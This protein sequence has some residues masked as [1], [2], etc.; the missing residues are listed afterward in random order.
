MTGF[1]RGAA[2]ALGCALWLTAPAAPLRADGPIFIRDAEIEATLRRVADPILRAA[3]VSPATTDLYLIQD[4][5][6]NA[7]VA[8]GQNIFL[9]TGMITQLKNIDQLR[10]V[11]AHET[12]HIAGGHLARRDQALSGG[13]AMV[14]LGLLGAA[15]AGI[16][17]APD[18]SVAIAA[19]SQQVATRNLLAYTRGEEAA[20]D[21][22]GARYVASAGGDASAILDVLR[23]V[24]GQE[25][26]MSSQM[27][28]YAQTHPMSS[29]RIS[30]LEQKIA[31]L[32][33]GKPPDP[34]DVY[35]YDRMVTKLD[36]FLDRPARTLRDHPVSD[37]SE[38]ATFARA[39]AYYRQPD[40]ARAGAE[41]DAL[42]AIRPDDP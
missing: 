36:A 13:R 6:M 15:A 29:E 5:E 16:A 33:K 34:E 31:K 9:H 40:L 14:L 37:R 19:G 25:A 2:F 3:G 27:D 35:W 7:F 12:G 23:I 21:Q 11:I 32:P 42:I 30:M 1:F 10:G 39:V 41:M 4:P 24:R 26:L 22:A 17:G 8:R 20:A 38:M 18:A 28:P